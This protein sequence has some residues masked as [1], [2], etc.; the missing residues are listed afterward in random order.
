MISSPVLQYPNKEFIVTTN[1]TNYAMGAILS[2]EK[3]NSYRPIAIASTI[4]SKA[5][6]NYSEKE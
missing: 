2:Q 3:V 4:L 5:E 6:Q 1:A